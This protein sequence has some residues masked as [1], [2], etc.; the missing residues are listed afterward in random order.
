MFLVPVMLCSKMPSLKAAGPR[1]DGHFFRFSVFSPLGRSRSFF[2]GFPFPIVSIFSVFFLVCSLTFQDATPHSMEDL[3]YECGRPH[4]TFLGC[5]PDALIVRVVASLAGRAWSAHI[6]LF[7][8]LFVGCL[9]CLQIIK[10][11]HDHPGE[12]D[13][14]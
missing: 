1:C 12:R 10:L 9:L 3:V 8:S 7:F 14:S 13:R 11:P 4:D 5:Q 2:S 6:V